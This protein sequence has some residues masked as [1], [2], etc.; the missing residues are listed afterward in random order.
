MKCSFLC[1][2]WSW[3]TTD[4]HLLILPF[5]TLISLHPW[6]SLHLKFGG[7]PGSVTQPIILRGLNYSYL[8]KP[9]LLNASITVE[10][11]K[12]VWEDTWVNHLGSTHIL[13]V[14]YNV[15]VA[16]PPLAHQSVIPATMMTPPPK[17]LGMSFKVMISGTVV[18]FT[19]YFLNSR[20][21]P[22]RD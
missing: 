19:F 5:T 12:E 7:L 4:T 6:L 14:F 13:P 15:K 11:M 1:W 17:W 8:F 9:G 18:A 10:A 16:Q 2:R 22:T 21:I 20:R 3:V